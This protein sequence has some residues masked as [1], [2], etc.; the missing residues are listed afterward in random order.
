MKF[1]ASVIM[2]IPSIG[3]INGG[4]ILGEIGNIHRFSNPTSF[5][6]LQVCFLLFISLVTSRL[7]QQGCPNIAFELYDMFL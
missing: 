4:M 2:T 3:Y 7:R 5:F 1:N 6:L